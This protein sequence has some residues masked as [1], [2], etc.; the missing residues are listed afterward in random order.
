[1]K[2]NDFCLMRSLL[3]KV[4]CLLR[5]KIKTLIKSCLLNSIL[6]KPLCTI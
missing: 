1:M 2:K 4:N 5:S 6:I 3:Y